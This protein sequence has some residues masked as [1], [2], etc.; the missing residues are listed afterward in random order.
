MKVKSLSRIR[1]FSTPWTAAYQAPLPTG[2]SRQDDWSGVPLPSPPTHINTPKYFQADP[3][4]RTVC[5]SDFCPSIFSKGFR[6]L[7]GPGLNKAW[8]YWGLTL[9]GKILNHWGMGTNGLMP[10]PNI[11]SKK[12]RSL[13]GLQKVLLEKI[14]M[15]SFVIL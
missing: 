10:Q 9:L 2:F 1:L 14:C 11:L 12:K 5:L 3:I 6:K 8:E 4:D 15:T 7:F 13:W